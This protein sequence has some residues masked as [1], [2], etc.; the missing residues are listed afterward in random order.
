[1][2]EK[3]G[4]GKPKT[5]GSG[6][7]KGTTNLATKEVREMLVGALSDAGGREYLLEQAKENPKAFMSL[8]AK[9]IPQQIEAT[10][11]EIPKL[12]LRDYTGGKGGK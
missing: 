6:R 4:K 2:G 8:V 9:L 5:P 1:M 11:S 12:I 7:K 3:G 10:I